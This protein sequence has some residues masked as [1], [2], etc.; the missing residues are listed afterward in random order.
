MD[1]EKIT[2]ANREAW[3]EATEKHQAARKDELK[4][5]FARPGFST[6]DEHITAKL[7]ELGLAGKN[8][9]QTSCNN[10]REVISMVNLGAKS[11]VGFDISDNAIAEATELA[12]I[13]GVDCSFVRTD[14]YEIGKEYTDTFDL[15]YIS[16]GAL[17]WLPD[18][19]RFFRIVERVLRSGGKLLIYET[20]PF[21]YCFPAEDEP[22][23]DPDN[24]LQVAYSY[25]R[26]EPWVNDV[27][28]DYVG[29]T[30]YEAKTSYCYTQRMSGIINPI[31]RTGIAIKELLEFDRDIDGTFGPIEKEKKVP[32]SY[33]LVGEKP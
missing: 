21:L 18:L 22:E 29:K 33:M 10:G 14:V 31:I 9:A 11:G 16:I 3:N 32:L 5:A 24:P 26:T 30:T 4:E 2:Q 8:V 1:I 27:G 17:V 7:I 6:L 23:F 19:E 25:F 20:H 12:N 13:A 28:I 15:V